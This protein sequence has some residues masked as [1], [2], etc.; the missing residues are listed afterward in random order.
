MRRSVGKTDARNASAHGTEKSVGSSKWRGR[1]KLE[2]GAAAACQGRRSW[3]GEAALLEEVPKK[4][5]RVLDLGSGDGRLLGLL[6]LACPAARG[7]AAG[8]PR[9]VLGH[10]S[11]PTSGH[12]WSC[13]PS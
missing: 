13:L 9:L 12:H 4:A 11:I 10:S 5:H 6:L 7:V 8:P 1:S 2:T 3:Q